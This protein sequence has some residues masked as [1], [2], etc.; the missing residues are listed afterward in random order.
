MNTLHLTKQAVEEG[1]FDGAV[2][3]I[4]DLQRDN[5][6]IPWYDGGVIDPWNHTEA[7]MGLTVLGRTGEALKAY[8]FLE[9]TQLA[10]GSW[11]AQYGAAVPMDE[12]KYTGDGESEKKIRDSNFC[13]YPATGILH[14]YLVTGDEAFLARF[15]PMAE[16]SIDFVLS[17]Q[18][19][20]GDIRWAA[21][22]E[23][24]PENDA[25]ITGCSSIYKSLATAWRLS[26]EAGAERPDWLN[27]RALLGEALR[28]KPHRFDRQWEKKDHFSMDWFYPVLAGVYRGDAGRARLAARWDQFVSE[29]KGC[30][31]TLHQPWV[32]VAESAELVMALLALGDRERA[33][34]VYS[35]LHQWRDE[36]GAYWMGYQYEAAV[37]WPD[38][39]PAWTAAAMIL[40]AD[41]LLRLTPASGLFTDPDDE[42]AASQ[43]AQEA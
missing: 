15:W 38:E 41:A 40:A 13:A 24:T 39:K 7:A 11:W 14:Y 32:T 25:L 20:H 12:S 26:V 6:A 43:A 19:E 23:G 33:A 17:L 31:C 21:H 30:R 3:R 1:F 9:N 36:D 22:D 28:T 5:G 35:W 4:C 10:D 29:G 37:P 18:T 27:A 2:R 34:A 8:A 42:E 16:R